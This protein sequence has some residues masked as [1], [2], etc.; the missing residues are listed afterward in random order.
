MNLKLKVL[1]D[2]Q[3]ASQ[4]LRQDT[5]NAVIK[6]FEKEK[7]GTGLLDNA[8]FTLKDVYATKTG[9]VR[10]SSKILENFQPSYN[11]TIVEK[12]LNN[13]A[14]LVA[15]VNNDELALGGTGTYSAFGLITNPK[16]HT[17]LSG[18]SSSGSVATF[19]KNISFA[20]GSDTGDSVRLPA[21]Y[22]GI[23]GFKPSYG[24]ISRYG[25]FAYASS[26][27]TIAYFAHNVNDIYL[28]SKT[29]YGIDP[30]DMTTVEVK[31]NELVET[32]PSKI[33]ALD[34]SEFCDPEVNK[35][36]DKLINKLKKQN[37]QVE[38]VKPNLDILRCIK[39]VYQVISFSEA[40]SNLANLTGIIFG[41]KVNGQ[42]YIE[43]M[44]KT[45]SQNFGIMV[46]ERLV[47]GSYFLYSENQEEIFIKAMK[48]RR[49]IRDY[50]K[51]LHQ[52]GD[53]VIYPSFASIAPLIK[54]KK[55]YDV[56]DYVLTGANLAGNPSLSIPLGTKNAMP[57]NLTIDAGL[58]EDNKLLNHSL[59]I[60]KMLGETN[61]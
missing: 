23:I 27:D 6:V 46:S 43:I 13:G 54:D 25:L 22:N 3:K 47:L 12:I 21:S 45:R 10:S 51:S 8:V 1:G 29:L 42:D 26:L 28:V 17:R 40:S 19:S 5:N 4:E 18:G 48:V 37:I 50:L 35:A 20:I 32:K 59:Y 24:A 36:F 31:L 49:V 52:M 39:P 38:L 11:A 9:F 14:L 34:F 30:K 57:F 15:T 41:N 53:V 2:F 44:T 61:E 55:S 33:V 60:K 56:M 58:Y 7:L 16:D